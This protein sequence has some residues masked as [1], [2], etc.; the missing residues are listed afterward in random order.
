[1]DLLFAYGADPERARV[2]TADRG[3]HFAQK[4]GVTIKGA[5]CQLTLLSVLNPV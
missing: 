5:N 1:M 3:S 2:D 4:C